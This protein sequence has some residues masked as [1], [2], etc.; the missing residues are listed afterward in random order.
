MAIKLIVAVDSNFG[1]G[2]KDELLFRIKEDLQR[3]KKLTTGHF[4]VMGRK[5][6]ESLPNSLPERINVV[7]TRNSNY[8]PNNPSVIVESNIHKI[9]SYYMNTGK[10]EKDL[11]I[12]GGAETYKQ[13]LPYVDEVHMTFIHKEAEKVDT[14]FPIEVMREIGF[15]LSMSNR[16]FSES[17]NCNVTFAVYRKS[18]K[19]T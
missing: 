13:F 12:I 4:V 3:F 11:W 5:T 10:Q 17:E 15:E 19:V 9:I 7:I 2:Y 1:I 14:Y 6:F 8:N 16:T 18:I